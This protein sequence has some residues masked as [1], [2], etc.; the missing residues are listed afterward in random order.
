MR[1]RDCAHYREI[2]S[3]RGDCFG[4]EVEGDRD[5]KESE[6]CKGQYFK[7]KTPTRQE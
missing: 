6:R 7:P 3:T 2:D 4:A 1:C 5:P